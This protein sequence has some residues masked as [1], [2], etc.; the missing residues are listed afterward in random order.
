MFKGSIPALVTPFQDGAVDLKA[1]TKLIERQI[2]AGC[3]GLVPCGTTGESATLTPEEHK[4]LVKLCVEVSDG[5]V[6]IIAGSGSNSTALAIK[7]AQSVQEV[8]ADAALVVAPYYNKPSQEGLYQHFKA[9]HDSVDI[10]IVLYNVPG[11]TVVDISI[12]T[13]CRAAEL[14]RIIGIKDAN[15]D[16]DRVRA[17]RETIGQDFCLLSGDD[18]SSG[19][20]LRNGGNGCITVSGNVAA[21]QV[22][23]MQTAWMAGETDIFEELEAL[24]Q[25]LHTAMF[26]DASPAPA[27]YALWRM[28][29]CCNELRLPMVCANT[30]ACR[31]IDAAMEEI[32]LELQEAA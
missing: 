6:P 17:F 18:E 8:G 5:H 13:V 1:Y 30:E 29:L 28:G 26:C 12:E 24:L 3:H 14:D 21:E 19:D 22:A 27:K 10:P 7:K 15:P 20:Y 2:E 11:R 31:I 16:M 4:Q 23:G 32:G 9:V 25:P